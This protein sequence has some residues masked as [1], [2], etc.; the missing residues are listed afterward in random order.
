MKIECVKEF[1]L[2]QKNVEEL[3]MLRYHN[4]GTAH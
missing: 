2:I 1:K 4:L 3:T